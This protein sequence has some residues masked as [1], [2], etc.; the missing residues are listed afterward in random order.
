MTGVKSVLL[1]ICIL[2]FIVMIIR[3]KSGDPFAYC[4]RNV[5][6]YTEN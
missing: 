5:Q 4:G 6:V 3:Y 2:G 1:V